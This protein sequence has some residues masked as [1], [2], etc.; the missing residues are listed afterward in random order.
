MRPRRPTIAVLLDYM[1]FFGGGYEADFRR[2]LDVRCRE[3]DLNLLLVFGRAL[4]EARQGSAAH[5]AVFDLFDKNTVDGVI[6]ASTLLSGQCGTEGVSAFLAQRYQGMPIASVGLAVP[7]VPSLIVDNRTG[8]DAVIEHLIADHGCRRIAFIAGTP[9]NP[10]AALRL[11]VYREVLE[12]HGL[13]FDPDLIE[14]G[15]F[16]KRSA[17]AAIQTILT[18]TEA[19]DAV[20]AAN[21]IMALGAI[22]ALRRHGFRVP[23]QVR[24]TGFDDLSLARLANPPLTTVAQPFQHMAAVAIGLILDQLAGKPVAAVTSLTTELSVRQSC[25]CEVRLSNKR[26]AAARSDLS[27]AD[28]LRVRRPAIEKAVAAFLATERHDG[29]ASARRLLD[30]LAAELGGEAEAFLRAIEYLLERCGDDN[31][32]YRGL[33]NA[34]TCLRGELRPSETPELAAIW[35]CALSQIALANTTAQVHHRLAVDESYLRLLSAG[36]AFSVAF[37]S[38]S[39]ERMLERGLPAAGVRTALVSRCP[40]GRLAELEPLVCLHDGVPLELARGRYPANLLFPPGDYMPPQRSSFLVFP[41]TFETQNLGIAILEYQDGLN[42]QHVLSDQISA[43]LKSVELH[44]A[45]IQKTTLHERSLQER[46]ATSKRMQSL[47]VLAGGVAHDLNNALGPLVGLPD[48][49]LRELAANQSLAGSVSE[50]SADLESIKS[51]AL[52]A[53]QTI[54]DLLTL[55][56]Q[57]HAEKEPIDLNRVVSSCLKEDVLRLLGQPGSNVTVSLELCSTPIV[58]RASEA[59][60]VRAITNLVHNAIESISGAGRVRVTSSAVCVGEVLSGYEQIEPGDYAV[61]T[62]ADDGAGIPGHELGRIF[63]PFF[64]KKR[65]GDRSGTG[66]GLAIVHGVVKEH[67]GFVD[68]TST[69]GRGTSFSLYFPRVA[70]AAR[71]S[72]RPETP[73]GGRARVLIVDDD[74]VQLRTGRRILTHLGYDVDTQSRGAS[75]YQLFAERSGESPYDLVILDMSLNEE[76]DGLE[77]FEQIQEL[78]PN[79]RAIVAS[80]HALSERVER[81]MARGLAWLAKPYTAD[82]LGRAVQAALRERARASGF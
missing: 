62:I 48:I 30:A 36:E 18:R 54:K 67:D 37:D 47:S 3:L 27:A 69:L 65:V 15:D 57:G 61:L 24:V 78:F 39:L 25:G 53:A 29:A 28:D 33:Q 63:E 41:L 45:V 13:P 1:N 71:I 46:L 8:M 32:G 38:A 4:G 58:I 43:A 77:L 16:V 70:E 51:A 40:D 26:D 22:E 10:E 76:R 17:F 59:H 60:L 6:V 34:V 72:Q 42:G 9:H 79:Q 82:D 31:Q 5:N 64:S 80:G 35:Y 2:A 49:I 55:G 14:S 20:V 52:R 75:A 66:L 12:R 7:G 74:P 81:A 19:L 50:V 56:R 68:V 44:E 11:A 21:D 23:R 73:G